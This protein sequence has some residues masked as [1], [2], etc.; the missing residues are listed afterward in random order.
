MRFS[1]SGHETF[2][3]RNYWPKKGLD[4]IWD[5]GTFNNDAIRDLGVGKNMVGSIRFWVRALGLV[6][7]NGAASELAYYIFDDD[8]GKDPY[9][10]DIGSVWLLHYL[11][12]TTGTASIY[13]LVFNYFRKTRIEFSREQLLS[14]LESTCEENK[15]N[16]SVNSLKKDIGVFINNYLLPEKSKSIESEIFG[17]LHEL[18]LLE[19]VRKQGAESY[20]K[21]ENKERISIAPRIALACI[22]MNRSSSSMTFFELSNSVNSVGSVLALSSPFLMSCINS[23]CEYYPD[24]IVYTEDAGVQV[25]QISEELNWST[26]LDDYYGK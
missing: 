18:G 3:C 11:L 12:V 20:F 2:T 16:Y 5:K 10:E 14:Y 13:N 15:F 6:D 25:L 7:S 26:V 8:T 22:L 1:F 23:V 4:H 24:K 21:L 19:R 9:L 17:L